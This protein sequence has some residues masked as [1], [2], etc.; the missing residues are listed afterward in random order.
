M[1]FVRA[2]LGCFLLMSA[3][4]AAAPLTRLADIRA[5][6]AE[7]AAKGIPV[8]VE[9]TVVAI[10]P[11]T[12]YQFFLNDGTTGCF[13]RPVEGGSPAGLSPG[14]Q[15]RVEGVTD[16]LGYYP[17]VRKA[18]V[19]VLG[20]QS[21]PTPI[22]PGAGQIFAPELDSQWVEVPAV[23]T[24]CD[25]G[26][27]RVTLALEIFGLPFKAELPLTP[28]A[29]DRAAALMQRPVSLC[30]VMGT[31]FNRQRQMTDRHFFVSSF[32]AITP[33]GPLADGEAS[34]LVNVDRLLSGG[35]GP[36]T[37][38]RVQGVVT[39]Q[40]AK[41]FYLRDGS[42][43]TL[44]QAA[45]VVNF[46]CGS[47]VEVEGYA[48]VAPFRPV[49]RAT[50]VK[51]MG[52]AVAVLP[53]PFDFQ[54]NDP[55]NTDLAALQSE[56]VTLDAEFLGRRDGPGD[57]ILQ[58]RGAG[59]FFE[60]FQPHT[61]GEMRPAL[62]VGDRV[63]LTGICELT[64]THALPRMGWVDGFRI[65]LPGVGGLEILSRAPWWNSRRLFIALG[66]A[67]MVALS[68]LIWT[69]VLRRRVKSQMA[70]ISENLRTEAVGEERDRMARELHDTLEQQLLGVAL[71]LDRIESAVQETPAAGI[72]SL[73]RR[74]LRFT[75]LEAR[76]SVWDLRSRVLEAHG[77][78]TALQGLADSKVE[79]APGPAIQVQVSGNEHPLPTGV[80]FH[81][82]R[83]AQEAITNATK[84]GDARHVTL[85]LDYLPEETRLTIRDDGHGFDPAAATS[86]GP[87][88]GLL[89]MRE[90]AAKI[91]ATLV[92]HSAPGKGC[93]IIANVP[94]V[95]NSH[96]S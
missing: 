55:Q 86:P 5:L 61:T 38:V 33:T 37:M 93:S 81:L 80:D 83:I 66:L 74:M 4:S 40:D 76:R 82:L 20:K 68:G 90:R 60:A 70:V 58:F 21:L 43:S 46:P 15:V 31:I 39:Q 28:D 54:K 11:S 96:S 48:A 8:R 53:A 44:I 67:S 59:Q 42:G 51:S 34:P 3:V 17:S 94:T 1:A 72:L 91:G 6:S 73:A 56:W 49:L 95:S 47:H 75:R 19:K 87:H 7:E 24:G 92:I 77:L 9:G 16:P 84:H 64:T 45:K 57:A 32:D 50:H 35:F 85:E 52:P 22:K 63:R 65:H 79:D 41:G 69:W 89:G 71:Q 27:D 23:I 88:F 18:R 36:A 78:A 62:A 29:E 10:E 2:I 12:R 30:G 13:I 14:D 25:V 26:D